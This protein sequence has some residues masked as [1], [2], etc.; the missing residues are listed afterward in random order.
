MAATGGLMELTVAWR[1]RKAK[2]NEKKT[3]S[4]VADVSIQET[5]GLY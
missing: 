3:E 4:G 5:D 1:L 2:N